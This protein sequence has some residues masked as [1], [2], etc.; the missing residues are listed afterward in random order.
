METNGFNGRAG[1]V[2]EFLR[3]V[4]PGVV[5]TLGI[6]AVTFI[7]SIS[8]TSTEQALAISLMQRDI[9]SI[10]VRMASPD[11]TSAGS[12]PMVMYREQI[13]SINERIGHSDDEQRR[14]WDRINEIVDR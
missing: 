11:Y 12:V 2:L 9:A 14:M 6:I 10:N 4:E 1:V 13:R 7:I 8:K 3:K 5:I